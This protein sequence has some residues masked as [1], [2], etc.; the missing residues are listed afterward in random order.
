MT[1]EEKNLAIG[2]MVLG[3][4]YKH[5][6]I[7]IDADTTNLLLWCGKCCKQVPDGDKHSICLQSVPDFTGS[8]LGAGY[9]LEKLLR[10]HRGL[11][12][13][14][15]FYSSDECTV[16]YMVPPTRGFLVERHPTFPAAVC[17][18]AFKVA[19]INEEELNAQVQGKALNPHR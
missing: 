18:V 11:Q 14:I 12:V 10:T 8:T 9:L 4:T 13:K 15:V 1:N 5:E 16:A 19:G 7:P 2:L 6:V 3:E 17:A